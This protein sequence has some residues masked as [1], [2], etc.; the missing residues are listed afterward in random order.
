MTISST[1]LSYYTCSLYY[2][3]YIVTHRAYTTSHCSQSQPLIVA[4]LVLLS[5]IMLLDRLELKVY[6]F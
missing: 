1:T 2:T 6:Y 4:S 3:A 5:K